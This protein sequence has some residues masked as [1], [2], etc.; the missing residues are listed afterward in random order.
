MTMTNELLQRAQEL[1]KVGMLPYALLEPRYAHDGIGAALAVRA[2]LYFKGG[3]TSS[4]RQAIAAAFDAYM[5][6]ARGAA[7]GE[8]SPIA[9]LWFN[10]KRAVRF[11][12]APSLRDLET[13]TGENDGFDACYVGGESAR[14]ASY[15]EFTT[16]CLEKFQADL[17]TRG[18]DVAVFSLP[19]PFV[20]QNPN[21][22]VQLFQTVAA[23]LE[24]VHG[25]AGLA[26]NLSPTGRT[27]NESSEYY[28]AQRLGPGVDVGDPLAMEVRDLADRIKTVDWLTLIDQAMLGRIGGIDALRSQLP[29]DWYD[30]APCAQ[31]LLIR[32][33]VAPEA[34]VARENAAPSAP[35]AYV[36]LNAALRPIVAD[37]VST[38][39]RGTVNGDAPVYNSKASSNAWLR[40]FDV[41]DSE[42]LKAKAALLDTPRIPSTA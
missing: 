5:A 39:Q 31:G 29:K 17:G 37:T 10:G 18:L 28:L 34:G 8:D 41:S 6:L 35:P 36:V 19:S 16:F 14:D 11:A 23:M 9:W 22:F 20:R 32:A 33:G 13:R 3:Y 7:E 21:A 38:L 40:R 26:I 12:K 2:A 25:H 42:L 15:F 27:E 24:A 4:K 30:L 1:S